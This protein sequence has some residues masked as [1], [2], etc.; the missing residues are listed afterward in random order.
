M[1]TMDTGDI[2]Y[3]ARSIADALHVQGRSGRIT[4]VDIDCIRCAVAGY[5]VGNA[6]YPSPQEIEDFENL[7][8]RKFVEKC[9]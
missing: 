8:M 5:L 9:P 7:A 1:T 2:S 6:C 3:A 4:R